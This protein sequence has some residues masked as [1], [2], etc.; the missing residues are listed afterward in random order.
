MPLVASR[1]PLLPG[2]SGGTSS[3][4]TTYAALI[5]CCQWLSGWLL[6]WQSF[7][8]LSCQFCQSVDWQCWIATWHASSEPP[9]A[10]RRR[11]Q[12]VAC[13]SGAFTILK[14]RFLMMND[15]GGSE[16][17]RSIASRLSMFTRPSF[18]QLEIGYS[19]ISPVEETCR[20][21]VM[22]FM[23]WIM[24]NTERY[25]MRQRLQASPHMDSYA[26]SRRDHMHS[27]VQWAVW[28]NIVAFCLDLYLI[29]WSRRLSGCC[30][31]FEKSVSNSSECRLDPSLLE[32]L[33]RRKWF[34]SILRREL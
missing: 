9:W 4:Q 28:E 14:S 5:P 20:V 33:A 3:C 11:S 24:W 22:A 34:A 2:S 23:D 7:D 26:Q 18:D 17:A 31:G 8:Q 27:C 6:P 10:A 29:S 12:P 15:E 32:P 19:L 1:A 21:Q 13:F 30:L 25:L 16:L